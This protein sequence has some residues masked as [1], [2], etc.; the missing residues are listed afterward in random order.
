MWLLSAGGSTGAGESRMSSVCVQQLMM[1]A[2]AEAPLFTSMWWL[3]LQ[4]ID[5]FIFYVL[6]LGFL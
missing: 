3:L 4:E 6:I 5:S 1:A 2:V